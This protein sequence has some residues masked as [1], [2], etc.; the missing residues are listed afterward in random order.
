MS[1]SKD[2]CDKMER[3]GSWYILWILYTIFL[4]MTIWA[5]T[6]ERRLSPSSKFTSFWIETETLTHSALCSCSNKASCRELLGNPS[7]SKLYYSRFQPRAIVSCFKTEAA[8]EPPKKISTPTF[9]FFSHSLFY[10][11]TTPFHCVQWTVSTEIWPLPRCSGPEEEGKG[12]SRK[13]S[14]S[15]ERGEP[16]SQLLWS[17]RE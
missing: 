6:K 12:K 2:C 10:S 15:A 4:T 8:K 1:I 9:F 7:Y 5:N 16:C 13:C 14:R 11:F 17:F 3:H